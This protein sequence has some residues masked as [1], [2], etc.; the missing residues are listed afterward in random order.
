MGY[1]ADLTDL[2]Q[3]LTS[4]NHYIKLYLFIGD[5]FCIFVKKHK[6]FTFKLIKLKLW[7]YIKFLVVIKYNKT[8]N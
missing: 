8:K 6:L 1:K 2:R 7:V 4:L 5:C 3:D